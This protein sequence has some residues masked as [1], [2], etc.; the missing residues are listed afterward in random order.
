MVQSAAPTS[1]L[2]PIGR[3]ATYS[4][5]QITDALANLRGL[6][7]PLKPSLPIAP[8]QPVKKARCHLSHDNSVP[9]SG[10]ASAEEEDDDDPASWFHD[11]QDDGIKGQNIVYP[12]PEDIADVIRVD[13]SKIHYSTFYEPR[14]EDFQ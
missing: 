14:D 4:L 6:Y 13:E 12:D 3:L 7:F 9:D 11:D 5:V 2:P 1:F 10:Y 8:V